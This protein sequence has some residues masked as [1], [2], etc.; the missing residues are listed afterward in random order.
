MSDQIVTVDGRPID[1]RTRKPIGPV[2]QPGYYPD[3][4]T[5]SQQK[6]WDAKT[7]EV[8]LD[9][10]NNVPEIRFF[11]PEEARLLKAVC[12]RV[13]P[14]D[15]RDESHKI[16]I[17]P[18]ID[19]RLYE[20]SHDG[21]RYEDMPPDGEAFQLGLRAIEEIAQHQYGCGFL[22]IG[23]REQDE[24]LRSLHDGK[25]PA[26]HEI[27]KRM[28]VH[29]FWMLLVSD[30]ADAYYSHPWAWDEIGFG[31][32]AY[33]RAYMRLERGEAEP[34]ESKEKRYEWG[35]PD[36]SLSGEFELVAGQLEHLGSPGQGGTH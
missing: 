30:C 11:S 35:P 36:N 10:V 33:P 2:A 34:W 18:Q 20:N 17:V 25:P 1:P 15:D 23:L 31:G 22:E 12:D 8:I 14:Q 24:I 32:P 13:L 27:W 6:F 28:A 19:K 4:S 26:A 7:R 29:R 3:F 5:L 9:R 21:Y 16:P